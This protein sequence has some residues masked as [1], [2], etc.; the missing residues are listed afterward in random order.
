MVSNTSVEV[1][2]AGETFDL[3]VADDDYEYISI[4]PVL[5]HEGSLEHNGSIA[6]SFNEEIDNSLE[7]PENGDF[8]QLKPYQR[9][10]TIH[11]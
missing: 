2:A 1:L 7:N 4:N 5:N 9:N 10:Q 6:I 11:K 8:F 3:L